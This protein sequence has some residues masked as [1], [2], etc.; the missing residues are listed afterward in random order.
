MLP[1]VVLWDCALSSYKEY[2]KQDYNQYLIKN[3]KRHYISE[4]GNVTLS[5]QTLEEV[6]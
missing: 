3:F 2:E 5:F 4:N 6:K 1:E